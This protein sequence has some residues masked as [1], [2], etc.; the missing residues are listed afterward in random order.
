[1]SRTLRTPNG[2]FSHASFVD[3]KFR[4]DSGRDVRFLLIAIFLFNIGWVR[5]SVLQVNASSPIPFE[6]DIFAGQ[7]LSA[8]MFSRYA[9][10]GQIRE[11]LDT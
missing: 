1:M 11:L 8:C 3:R 10:H 5:M 7:V 2:W 6:N 9:L 4:I